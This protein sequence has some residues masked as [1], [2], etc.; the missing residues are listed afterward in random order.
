[1]PDFDFHI[2]EQFINSR[3]LDYGAT[4]LG[5]FPGIL[6]SFP[7]GGFGNADRLGTNS[8]AGAVHK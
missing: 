6:E 2:P 4:E 5:P 1:V 7:V 3:E 8:K